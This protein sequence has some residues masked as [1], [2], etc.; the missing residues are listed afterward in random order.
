MEIN[1]NLRNYSRMIFC[2]PAP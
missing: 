2:P 1:P